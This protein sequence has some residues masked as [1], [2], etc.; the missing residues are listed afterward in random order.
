V[1]KP[2]RARSARRTLSA[3]GAW[4]TTMVL[5]RPSAERRRTG[6]KIS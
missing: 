1:R 6:R 2:G 4:R 5:S 3:I